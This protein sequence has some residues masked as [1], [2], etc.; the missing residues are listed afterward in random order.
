M[1]QSYRTFVAVEIPKEVSDQAGRLI[2]R[3][4]RTSANVKWVES[5]N[6]HLTLK[7][8]GDVEAIFIP[9]VC[10]AVGAAVA[11]QAG[12]E[13]ELGG[14]GAFPNINRPRTIWLGVTK[15][16]D[17]LLALHDAI[18][19]ALADLGFRSETR[20]FTPHLTI[21]RVKQPSGASDEL[22]QLIAQ[23]DGF[24]A[25]K[26]PVDEVAIVSSKLERDG[27]VYTMLGHSALA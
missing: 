1:A 17:E 2:A 3:L 27:P 22:S 26:L 8:L 18:D 11:D 13:L 6:L 12:F 15:G 5:E 16:H 20:R 14:V 23:H 24:V 7:F 21:G 4:E 10:K 25:G 19:A 9:D